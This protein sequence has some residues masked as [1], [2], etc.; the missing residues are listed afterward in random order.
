MTI[1]YPH[2]FWK[3]QEKRTEKSGASEN[4][5]KKRVDGWVDGGYLGKPAKP[6]A[7][8]VSPGSH[9]V[10]ILILFKSSLCK[11]E[12]IRLLNKKRNFSE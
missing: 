12:K 6:C 11:I 3:V 10:D 4:D 2:I 7:P 9:W 1:S 5:M 8:G